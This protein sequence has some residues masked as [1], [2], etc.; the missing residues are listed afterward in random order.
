MFVL[1][2][3]ERIGSSMIVPLVRSSLELMGLSYLLFF[4]S[5]SPISISNC[6]KAVCQFKARRSSVLR[7][8]LSLN[9]SGPFVG[10]MHSFLDSYTSRTRHTIRYAHEAEP[11]RVEIH[12]TRWWKLLIHDAPA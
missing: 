11:S 2:P 12:A 8:F 7:I 1:I 5:P 6:E 10:L 9:T 3:F 4:E